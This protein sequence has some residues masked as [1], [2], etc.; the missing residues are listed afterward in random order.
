MTLRASLIRLAAADESMRPVL[1]PL[2]AKYAKAPP[3]GHQVPRDVYMR[4]GRRWLDAIERKGLRGAIQ[5]TALR[6][7]KISEG[8]PKA[9]GLAQYLKAWL[10]EEKGLKGADKAAIKKL[11]EDAEYKAHAM[12]ASTQKQARSL[13]FSQAQREANRILRPVQGKGGRRKVLVEI[14]KAVIKSP[15]L[16]QWFYEIAQ[17]FGGGKV[18]YESTQDVLGDPIMGWRQG[19]EID[20]EDGPYDRLSGDKL[21]VN[22]ING[23][24]KNYTPQNVAA[25][26]DFD[27][28]L[29]L[30]GNNWSGLVKVLGQLAADG[31]SP[32]KINEARKLVHEIAKALK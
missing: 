2:L 13:S 6:L 27:K 14:A 22:A 12:V 16:M 20:Q 17:E 28:I 21:L 4:A 7:R 30:V 29:R 32:A 26:R 24:L 11:I 19:W 31:E 10:K 9:E 5:A 1:L 25:G 23:A 15:L 18:S 8:S 3:A